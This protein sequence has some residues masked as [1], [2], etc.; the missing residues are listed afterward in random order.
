M[1]NWLYVVENAAI[2]WDTVSFKEVWVLSKLCF[3]FSNLLYTESSYDKKYK[4]T[5]EIRGLYASFWNTW[6]LTLPLNDINLKIYMY[7]YR[8]MAFLRLTP[9]VYYISLNSNVFLWFNF[10]N[11][12]NV[13][14]LNTNTW[15]AIIKFGGHHAQGA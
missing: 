4:S 15:I 12:L 8:I 9:M 14:I 6:P 7:L 10:W 5:I 13:C 2:P 3:N 11:L 1:Y